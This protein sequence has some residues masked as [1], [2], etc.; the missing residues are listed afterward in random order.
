[1]K[2]VIQRRPLRATRSLADWGTAGAA[3]DYRVCPAA[4]VRRTVSDV[5]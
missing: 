1:M 2:M 3:R 5:G 4:E